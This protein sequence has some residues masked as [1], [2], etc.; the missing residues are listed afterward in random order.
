MNRD[1]AYLIAAA[2]GAAAVYL[3]IGSSSPLA[4]KANAVAQ[5]WQGTT[6]SPYQ[7]RVPYYC[8]GGLFHPPVA[9]EGRTGLLMHG[10]GWVANPPSEA[11]GPGVTDG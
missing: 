6:W 4:K 10:W 9:G 7:P 11:T 2:A 8:R 5:G 1:T 3:L